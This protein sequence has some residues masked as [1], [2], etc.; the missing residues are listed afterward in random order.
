[1]KSKIAFKRLSIIPGLSL[2]LHWAGVSSIRPRL[3]SYFLL[4]R[5]I[6]LA[7]NASERYMVAMQAQ[8]S[9]C[10]LLLQLAGVKLQKSQRHGALI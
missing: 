1:L 4:G 6:L 2:V 3:Y 9:P 8:A 7:E 10:A 5:I